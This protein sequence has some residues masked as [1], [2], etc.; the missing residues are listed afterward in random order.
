MR[1]ERPE[2]SLLVAE[3][4]ELLAEQLH[5]LWQIEELVRR[6]DRLPIPA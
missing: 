1:L 5:L 2:A 3:D 6:A 4:D